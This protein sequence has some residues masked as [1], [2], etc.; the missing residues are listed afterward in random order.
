MKN[1]S[2]QNDE[3]WMRA[4]LKAAG[5][6]AKEDEVPVGA[7]IV[8]ENQIIAEGW[9]QT[10]Q[11]HDPS[12][13][14]E[15]VALRHAGRQLQNYRLLGTTLYV[16]LEPCMMC[17]SAMV[18]ARI[19]RVVFGAKDPKTGAC[20]GAVDGLALPQWNHLLNYTGEILAVECAE[21]LT[22]FFKDRRAK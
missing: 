18:H 6:A 3:H 7:I 9:N 2:L 15:V 4:A 5:Q 12:A 21:I 20:G 11:H 1:L 10:I 19:T 8:H 14:A 16:T 13:H 17:L 22:Q